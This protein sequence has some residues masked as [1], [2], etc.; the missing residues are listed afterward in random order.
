MSDIIGKGGLMRLLIAFLTILSVPQL[1]AIDFL[2]AAYPELATSAR[3]LAMGNAFIAEVEDAMSAFY[4][5]AG[6]GTVRK[7]RMHLSNFSV[8]TNRDWL[9]IGTK[10]SVSDAFS[11]FFKGFGLDGQRQLLLDNRG[12]IATNRIQFVPNF[13]ARYIS[14]GFFLSQKTRAT[15]GKEDGAQFEYAKRL[16]YGPYTALNLSL[17]GGI[18]KFGLTGMFLKRSEAIGTAD[19]TVTFELKDSDYKKGSM[20]MTIAGFKLTLPWSFLP[21]FALT[22]HNAFHKNFGTGN[23]P[24]M[25]P[26][27]L[28]VGF[29]MTPQIGKFTRMHLEINYRDANNVRPDVSSAR[30]ILAGIEFDFFR[31][32]YLRLGY[33]DGFGSGGFGIRTKRLIFDFST[34]AVDTTANEFRGAEDRRFI[35]T[36]SAGL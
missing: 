20:L 9:A 25:I 18:L 15:I 35:F 3:G 8:E 14:M 26:Q 11:N 33:G 21:T 17:F 6:L 30:K 32:L 34:Y 24:D 4:N 19:P 29:G 27:Q 13:T 22:Y 5:P 16:D 31:K 28:D 7:A 10:G 2:D 1:Y 36:I 12:K 23:V